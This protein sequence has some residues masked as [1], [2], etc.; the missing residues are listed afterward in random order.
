MRSQA[1]CGSSGTRL[2]NAPHDPCD[3]YHSAATSIGQTSTH[4][5]SIF[6]AHHGDGA[7][8]TDSFAKHRSKDDEVD[9]TYSYKSS[10][11]PFH[12]GSAAVLCACADVSVGQR[13]R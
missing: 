13:A 3:R 4:S 12:R 9:D 10:P 11:T 2:R 1:L 7:A 6:P 8:L 5:A